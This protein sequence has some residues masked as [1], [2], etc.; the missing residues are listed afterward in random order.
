MLSLNRG[1][2]GEVPPQ[3]RQASIEVDE[4]SAVI[5]VRFEYDGVPSD[6]ARE[7]CLC[8]ATEAIGDYGAPWD[9]DEQHI[10]RPMPEQLEGLRYL[11]YLRA[12][13]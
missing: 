11:V 12:E 6:A 2:L 4:T 8:A 5:R 10:S 1:L 9:L 3:L 7:S 13:S